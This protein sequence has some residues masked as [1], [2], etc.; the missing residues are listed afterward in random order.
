MSIYRLSVT[1]VKRRT[2]RSAV[3]AAAYRAGVNLTNEI[4]GVVHRY[5]KRKG[6]VYRE[7]V[8]PDGS[9]ADWALDRQTLW[10]AAERIEKRKDSRTATE[11]QIAL[12]HELSREAAIRLL[13]QFVAEVVA[14]YGVA[15][16]IAV[17]VP[18]EDD[19]KKN[20]HAH[21]LL[22]TR[23]VMADGLGPKSDLERSNG[24]LTRAGL[25][26][27]AQQLERLRARWAT[28]V[29]EALAAAKITEKV[30]H[31]S[32]ARR[33]IDVWPQTQQGPTAH[34][35]EQRAKAGK[36]PQPDR[37]KLDPKAAAYNIASI[38]RN[39]GAIPGE[40]AR[41][42]SVF[43]RQDLARRLSSLVDPADFAEALA[44]CE[45]A[46]V[47]LRPAGKDENGHPTPPLYSTREQII[48]EQRLAHLA[49]AMARRP[50]RSASAHV[51]GAVMEAWMESGHRLDAEQIAAV[52][53]VCS[54][55][56]LSIL[57]GR[58]GAGK[59]TTMQAAAAAWAA[60]GDHVIG[61]AVS[62][63]AAELLGRQAGLKSSLTVAQLL[64]RLRSGRLT[65]RPRDVI[66]IDEASMVSSAD[67]KAIL[68]AANAAGSK[69]V[70]VGD[71]DQLQSVA[72]GGALRYL[73]EKLGAAWMENIRRQ[74]SGTHREASMHLAAGRVAE[75][76]EIY[77][78][79]GSIRRPDTRDGAI[80][81]IARAY[82]HGVSL[83]AEAL[84]LGHSR[85][86]VAD[87]NRAIRDEL[88]AAGH[89]GTA[90]VFDGREFRHG[91]RV[92]FRRKDA[93]L[94]VQN[95]TMGRVVDLRD[96]RMVVEIEGDGQRRRVAF[97]ASA[98]RAVAYG[99]AA[100]IHRAQGQTADHVMVLGGRYWDRNLAY[101]ALTRHRS[102]VRIYADQETFPDVA[103]IIRVMSRR[104][105]YGCTMDF[106]DP[107]Y[108]APRAS[109]GAGTKPQEAPQRPQEAP[110]KPQEA[111][112][113]ARRRN[114][115]TDG[116]SPS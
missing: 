30:D 35:Q 55:A 102:K 37:R 28:L 46:S 90:A 87:L 79:E 53:H 20:I 86:D 15:A 68:E 26:L 100:T 18:G 81:E 33:G 42:Q 113:A 57:V 101:V 41:Q 44:R 17:H 22:T 10:N 107:L 47:L 115:S 62:G 72:A 76:L 84:V 106:V 39:P 98:Y 69:V 51:A 61:L 50:R 78:A 19:N 63:A 40:L 94:G 11:L 5:H 52:K 32:Y 110:Q 80:A 91:E 34:A 64:H 25:P 104:G 65:L 56:A 74:R 21:V 109:A 8:I 114:P 96:G 23:K 14:R 16:D 48:L 83:G 89:L 38:R 67:L 92:V 111:P 99:Y 29:N 112:K 24:D 97:D 82:L 36:G 6:V 3:A 45:A 12:P 88:I 7:I 75:A 31:R 103:D 59:T 93:R 27:G 2:G 58:A 60:N 70:L 66:L 4:D 71:P 108:E 116:P 73:V 13:K 49:A 54:G 43:S 95:G 77:A 85:A 105:N 1:R 9:G